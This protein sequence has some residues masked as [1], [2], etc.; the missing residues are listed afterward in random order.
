MTESFLEQQLFQIFKKPF[1]YMKT[2]HNAGTLTHHQ[3]AIKAI[4]FSSA[5]DV[6]LDYPSSCMLLEIK[7]N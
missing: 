5:F 2:L 4:E 6:S 3:G 1:Q 7:V